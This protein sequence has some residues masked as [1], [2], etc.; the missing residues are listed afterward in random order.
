LLKEKRRRGFF[1]AAFGLLRQFAISGA[2]EA[3]PVVKQ[4]MTDVDHASHLERSAET[5]RQTS[6]EIAFRLVELASALS[7]FYR[8]MEDMEKSIS[9]TVDATERSAVLGATKRLLS[10]LRSSG[11]QPD[12]QNKRR[13]LPVASAGVAGAVA[14]RQNSLTPREKQVLD[15]VVG[16]ATS[17]EGAVAINISP[18]TFEGHRAKIMQKLQAKNVADLVLKGFGRDIAFARTTSAK[19]GVN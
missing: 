2:A 11:F 14:A 3:R 15:L 13:G 10:V 9:G 7:L 4:N 8:Q 18:R 19:R 12:K 16:G 17:R 5:A 6:A 1:P